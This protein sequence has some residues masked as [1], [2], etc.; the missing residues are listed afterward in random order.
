MEKR[1][2]YAIVDAD[3]GFTEVFSLPNDAIAIRAFTESVNDEKSPMNK[4][5]EKFKLVSCGEIKL[6]ETT[7]LFKA[8]QC[9][10]RKS[11]KNM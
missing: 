5:P 6:N 3:L 10:I 9:L 11:T 2:V 1:K 8:E 7:D 4:Y